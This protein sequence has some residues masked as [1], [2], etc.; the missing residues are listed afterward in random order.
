MKYRF[1]P[2][3]NGILGSRLL[4][5]LLVSM[6]YPLYPAFMTKMQVSTGTHRNLPRIK[7][8]DSFNV[9]LADLQREHIAII[10]ASID[11]CLALDQLISNH[12]LLRDQGEAIY[13]LFY[14]IRQVGNKEASFRELLLSDIGLLQTNEHAERVQ[15]QREIF[16]ILSNLVNEF[17]LCNTESLSTIIDVIYSSLSSFEE[18]HLSDEPAKILDVSRFFERSIYEYLRDPLN[19]SNFINKLVICYDNFI[20]KS[21]EYSALAQLQAKIISRITKDKAIKE[22]ISLGRKTFSLDRDFPASVNNQLEEKYPP[23]FVKTALVSYS[24]SLIRNT[25]VENKNFNLKHFTNYQEFVSENPETSRDILDDLYKTDFNNLKDIYYQDRLISSSNIDETLKDFHRFMLDKD[26]QC[27]DVTHDLV[28]LLIS[29]QVRF[30]LIQAFHS[31]YLQRSLNT[32]GLNESQVDAADGVLLRF[33]NLSYFS[34]KGATTETIQDLIRY[35]P[36]FGKN[37]FIKHWKLVEKSLDKLQVIKR[38][39]ENKIMPTLSPFE[40]QNKL[41]MAKDNY[42]EASKC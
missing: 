1:T 13:D 26:F 21:S 29:N 20:N 32:L 40:I 28:F 34:K 41:E 27:E 23:S 9:Q 19:Q 35:F 24:I 15:L 42:S 38:A 30:R 25:P 3:L 11:Y 2:A 33:Q 14:R 17:Q 4:S 18:E 36:N 37:P 12:E 10:H 6:H 16:I 5:N 22:Y 7:F 8:L 39:F 31:A